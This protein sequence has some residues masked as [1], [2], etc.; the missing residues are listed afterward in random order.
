MHF[1]F[2]LRGQSRQHQG[3]ASGGLI[4]AYQRDVKLIERLG[5]YLHRSAETLPAV[6]VSKQQPHK[7]SDFCSVTLD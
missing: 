5:I 1:A 7:L 4:R 6:D 3:E 2:C